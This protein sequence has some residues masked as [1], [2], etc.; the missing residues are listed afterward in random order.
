MF[1]K[2]W[3]KIAKEVFKNAVNHGFWKDEV[4]DGERMALIHAE[5]SEALEA[6][7]QGNPSSNKII[8][9]SNLEEELADVVI[10]IMDYAFGK[11]LDIAGAILAKIE[12]NQS[13]EYMHGKSFWGEIMDDS[14]YNNDAEY[15]LI[16][17]QTFHSVLLENKDKPVRKLIKAYEQ[18]FKFQLDK[19]G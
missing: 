3:N 10:R 8:E 19:K 2:E 5:I 16:M 18:Y 15:L 11:D 12:Y 13:R 17:I 1:E 7:R 9:Y 4:N 6:L 14:K